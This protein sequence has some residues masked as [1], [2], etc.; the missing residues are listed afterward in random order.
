MLSVIAAFAAAAITTNAAPE[1]PATR[2]APSGPAPALK[3]VS[4]YKIQAVA[5]ASRVT[6]R[7]AAKVALSA[8]VTTDDGASVDNFGAD[9]GFG[10][11]LIS[12]PGGWELTSIHMPDGACGF[13]R[14]AIGAPA[15]IIM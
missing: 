10:G 11:K 15:I 12:L 1:Q 13:G 7:G 8:L 3:S 5:G 9:T 14:N 2:T 6:F 4:G